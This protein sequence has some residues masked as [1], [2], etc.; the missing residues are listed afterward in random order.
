MVLEAT[1]DIACE[2]FILSK[3]ELLHLHFGS[4]PVL[5]VYVGMFVFA[6]YVLLAMYRISHR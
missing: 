4:S 1:I 3:G 5:A 2:V 6:Q